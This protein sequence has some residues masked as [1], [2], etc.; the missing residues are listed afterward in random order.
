MFF[1]TGL[2]WYSDHFVVCNWFLSQVQTPLP[3]QAE[4]PKGKP[5]C[6]GVFCLT[7]DLKAVSFGF[8]LETEIL[9]DIAYMVLL[10]IY[11]STRL[12]SF[13]LLIFSIYYVCEYI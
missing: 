8:T 9:V 12:W 2:L 1:I 6:Y 10:T 5:E 3:V 4:D 13:S 11:Y 7:Y